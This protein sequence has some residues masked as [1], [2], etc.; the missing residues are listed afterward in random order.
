[1][2]KPKLSDLEGTEYFDLAEML[3]LETFLQL[4]KFFE[5]S[6]IYIPDYKTISKK[7]RARNIVS[8]FNQGLG[9][10]TLAT[11]YN[12]SGQRIRQILKEQSG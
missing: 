8:D 5:K 11:K 3:G 12:L 6:T 2:Y 4:V 10:K 9:L 1:M 7:A